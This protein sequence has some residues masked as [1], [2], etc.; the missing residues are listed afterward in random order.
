[1]VEIREQHVGVSL[2]Q[3]DEAKLVESKLERFHDQLFCMRR[4][5]LLARVT[6][7]N[8]IQSPEI[9]MSQTRDLN[10][11]VAADKLAIKQEHKAMMER[12]DL[13]LR[14]TLKANLHF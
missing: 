4:F 2:R 10:A 8:K 13:D 7:G 6:I 9:A 11:E 3:H 12:L 5:L 1:L 14:D